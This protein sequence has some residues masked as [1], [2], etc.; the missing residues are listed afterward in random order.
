MNQNEQFQCDAASNDNNDNDINIQ[1]LYVSNTPM[2]PELW[3]GNFHPISLHGSVEQIT[4]D[5]KSIKDLLNFMARYI[6]NKKV[7]PSKANNLS[8]FNSIGDSIWNFISAVY[9][10]NWD[11]FYSDNKSTTLRAKI[12]SKFTPRIALSNNKSNKEMTKTIPVTIDKVPL[13]PPLPVKSKREVNLSPNTSRT[14]NLWLKT[15]IRSETKSQPYLTLRLQNRL[16]T[17][18]RFLKSKK[19]SW[20]LMLR[21]STKLTTLSK[22]TQSLNLRFK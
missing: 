22:E 17:L 10:A 15:R 20:L 9:Q 2:E 14:R 13:P 6:N 4:S 19:H 5:T 7:N 21:K 12:T 18:L 3:S 16:Q 1:L 8:D 11:V